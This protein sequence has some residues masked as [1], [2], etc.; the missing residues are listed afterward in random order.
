MGAQYNWQYGLYE[1]SCNSTNVIDDLIFTV[2]AKEL[3]V[4]ASEFIQDWDL[5]DGMCGLGIF[6]QMFE[7]DWLLGDPFVRVW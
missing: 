7:I 4:P 5:D 6:G 3:A 2:N 1:V